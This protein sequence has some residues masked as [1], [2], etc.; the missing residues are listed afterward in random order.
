M[1]KSSNTELLSTHKKMIRCKLW[2]KCIVFAFTIIL[3]YAEESKAKFDANVRALLK[4]I[5]CGLPL[6][7]AEINDGDLSRCNACLADIIA[8]AVVRPL[9]FIA[10]INGAQPVAVGLVTQNATNNF[11]VN[12]PAPGTQIPAAAPG[13]WG[14][15]DPQAVRN[16]I[17]IAA[18]PGLQLIGPEPQYLQKAKLA[19]AR[20]IVAAG[21]AAIGARINAAAGIVVPNMGQAAIRAEAVVYALPGDAALF[22]GIPNAV[23]PPAQANA[24]D[25]IVASFICAPGAGQ[26]PV[27]AAGPNLNG[28]V[29]PAQYLWNHL[30]ERAHLW[31]IPAALALATPREIDL[32]YIAC[33]RAARVGTTPP[34]LPVPGAEHSAFVVPS[35]MLIN[36]HWLNV[37]QNLWQSSVPNFANMNVSWDQ[38]M[39]G[40][41][42]PH[43][44]L[45]AQ[46]RCHIHISAI[47]ATSTMIKCDLTTHPLNAQPAP[48]GGNTGGAAVNNI[49]DPPIG[50]APVVNAGIR[51]TLVATLREAVAVS[52]A[53]P[54]MFGGF[55]PPTDR[56]VTPAS[57]SNPQPLNIVTIYVDNNA[58]V[59]SMFPR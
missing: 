41:I 39:N 40:I 31:K 17:G 55:L 47:N 38:T 43:N 59:A 7:E 46:W 16:A 34:Q 25:R 42:I 49:P 45:L 51:N 19:A 35:G 23:V 26:V 4:A 48:T 57:A 44:M 8:N 53:L 58:S 6:A 20:L 50:H 28:A 32:N 2:M 10:E 22:S 18:G 52:S 29:N 54:G 21:R 56:G 3:A 37:L 5:A 27:P 15:V 1:N 12:C 30:L 24:A 33:A 11:I 14:L 13:P 9:A 36:T